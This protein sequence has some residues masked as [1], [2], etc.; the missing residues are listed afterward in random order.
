M[1][2]SGLAATGWKAAF[3]AP[4]AGIL[5]LVLFGTRAWAVSLFCV[6]YRLSNGILTVLRVT[7]PQSLFGRDHFGDI[8]GT[9]CGRAGPTVKGGRPVGR[10]RCVGRAYRS[11]PEVP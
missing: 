2:A 10:C 5:A 3:S 11:G 8:S 7:L 6:L 9:M 1:G 4:P